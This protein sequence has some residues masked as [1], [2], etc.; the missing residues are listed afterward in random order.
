VS[1]RRGPG[2]PVG[3]DGSAARRALLDAA[4]RRFAAQ[5]YAATT[6]RQISGDAGTLAGNLRHHLGSKAQ[7][8]GA[9]NEDCLGRVAG[10]LAELL[11]SGAVPTPGGY[12][13]LL[14][15]LLADEPALMEFLAVAPLERSRHAELQ[16]PLGPGPTSLEALVRDTLRSWALD[17]RVTPDVAPDDLADALIATSFGL[18]VYSTRVDPTADRAAMVEALARLIDGQVWTSP[19]VRPS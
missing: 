13:R 9:V 17:G 6:T 18:L 7:V 19:E 4:R 16:G 14:G 2:R 11:G 1:D 15:R 5:G 10:L 12:V 8:F 3:S